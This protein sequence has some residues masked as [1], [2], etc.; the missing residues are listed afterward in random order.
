MPNEMP[1]A[2]GFV[3]SRPSEKVSPPSRTRRGRALSHPARSAGP[4]RADHV[5]DPA[6]AKLASR[7][8]D[9]RVPRVDHDRVDAAAEESVDARSHAGIGRGADADVGRLLAQCIA[10]V[11]RACRCRR[12]LAAGRSNGWP[13]RC[14]DRACHG[15]R[16]FGRGPC[17][18]PCP[19]ST[20][21]SVPT[22]FWSRSS[23]LDL[24]PVGIRTRALSVRQTPPPAC[25]PDAAVLRGAVRVGDER[26][27]RGW[28]CCSSPRE[29]EHPGLRVR[30]ARTVE[31][32]MAPVEREA[33]GGA[34]PAQVTSCEPVEG[35][36]RARRDRRRNGLRRVRVRHRAPLLV[37]SRPFTDHPLRGLARLASG[38]REL[39]ARAG[40][41]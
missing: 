32:P 15:R 26:R 31:P 34:Q 14:R 38:L 6:N 13:H 5:R 12:R 18:G 20:S 28:P 7:P 29:R 11:H 10:G 21:V 22:A 16:P 33:P 4:G 17:R 24:F 30:P 41:A 37:G 3:S 9:G 1:R 35:C 23:G 36:L 39:E 8:A 25:D 27:D 40:L 19:G 2:S